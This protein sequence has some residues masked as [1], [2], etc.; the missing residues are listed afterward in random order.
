MTREEHIARHQELHKAL[1]ELVADYLR[2]HPPKFTADN[3]KDHPKLP[4]NTTLLELMEWSHQQ[5]ID[6]AEL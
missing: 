5:T 4:S 3:V 6:P 1:D 2:H